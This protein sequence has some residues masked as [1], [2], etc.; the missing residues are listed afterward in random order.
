MISSLTLF[1]ASRIA[2][3]CHSAPPEEQPHLA[4]LIKELVSSP[5]DSIKNPTEA[6]R[7]QLI[8][9]LLSGAWR[10]APARAEISTME[11]EDLAQLVLRSGAGGLGWCKLRHSELGS[12]SAGHQFHQAYR[13]QALQAA[14]HERNLKKI[15]PLMREAGVEP[16]L[17]KGW[18]IARRYQE[19]AA[20]P[21]SDFDF[22]VAT[23]QYAAANEVLMSS[24]AHSCNV[25]LHEGFG[26]FYE[27][28]TADIFERSEV[29]KLDGL[30]V[31]ILSAEDDLRFLCMHLLRHGA[32]RPIWLCDVAVLLESRSDNFD[33]DRCL[34]GSHRQ[35][36]WVS[37]AVALTS[38][39]L[40]VSL[41]NTPIKERKLPAW[42][43]PAV[44]R[45]WGAP[46][47]SLT[48]VRAL[49]RN[50]VRSIAGLQRELI[51]HWPNPIEATMSVRGAFNRLPRFPYQIGHLMSRTLALFG[52]VL[53]D[54]GG[55]I[56][57]RS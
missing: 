14:L 36:D 15:I 6:A 7:G 18:A 47:K 9:T 11:L 23:D 57:H 4:F 38:E 54:R 16:L 51:R 42:L 30:D 29:V 22:C 17:V 44:L 32:A 10:P 33:W 2:R 39:L 43:K 28:E 3:Q 45:S 21:Y 8:A 41:E 20:R 49:M 1:N 26:K 25:D 35:S 53:A 48:Q 52:Q 56:Q 27:R 40:G 50:P 19:P 13:L 46:A 31:R 5:M 55:A 34:S 24:E 37:C 12:S